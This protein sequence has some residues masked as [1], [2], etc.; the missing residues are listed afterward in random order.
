MHIVFPDRCNLAGVTLPTS[1]VGVCQVAREGYQVLVRQVL[2]FCGRIAQMTDNALIMAK[3]VAV[4]KASSL[5]SMAIQASV[6][7]VERTCYCR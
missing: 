5:V 4:D 6:W 2:V 7:M 1:L 3:P